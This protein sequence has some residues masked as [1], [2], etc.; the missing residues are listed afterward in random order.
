M[1][2]RQASYKQRDQMARLYFNIWPFISTKIC[3]MTHK[4]SQRRSKILP[5]DK[6]TLKTKDISKVA[7]YRQI[8]SHWLQI[9]FK[10]ETTHRRLYSFN[11][12]NS[13]FMIF[14]VFSWIWVQPIHNIECVYSQFM[15]LF[16]L[17]N[18]QLYSTI[19]SVFKWI[20]G[21]IGKIEGSTRFFLIH[22]HPTRRN[23][24]YA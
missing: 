18:S 17:L 15:T 14:N 8:W 22:L 19:L 11:W 1:F 23:L 7:K 21:H 4:I 3:P 13:H 24:K 16:F 6:L 10:F 9:S 20:F 2:Q 12:N 5:N